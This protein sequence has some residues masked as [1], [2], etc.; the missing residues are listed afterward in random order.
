MAPIRTFLLTSCATVLGAT[1]VAAAL[2]AA[3]TGADHGSSDGAGA[4]PDAAAP[5]PPRPGPLLPIAPSNMPD[6]RHCW[7]LREYMKGELP[8]PPWYDAEAPGES[9]DAYYARQA[10]WRRRKWRLER[11]V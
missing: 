7:W 4:A 9:S 2:V 6:W 11:M 1:A 10:E 5:P 8:L 3:S